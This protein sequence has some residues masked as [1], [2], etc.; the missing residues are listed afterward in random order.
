MKKFINENLVAIGIM[1]GLIILPLI[2][3]DSALIKGVGKKVFNN[4]EF[5][6]NYMTYIGTVILGIVTVIQNKRLHDENKELEDMNKN[7]LTLEKANY[8]PKMMIMNQN[9]NCIYTK[10]NEQLP[11]VINKIL[12]DYNKYYNQTPVY[13]YFV[14]V[15]ENPNKYIQLIMQYY[16][17][18]LSN[19]IKISNVIMKFEGEEYSRNAKLNDTIHMLFMDKTDCYFNIYFDS[20]SKNIEE[21]KF[22]VEIFMF[23]E[24]YTE[25]IIINFERN[26]IYKED[27]NTYI[28]NIKYFMEDND[29]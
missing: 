22:D 18:G 5:W 29:E 10:E 2:C 27:T 16:G 21:L 26:T 4:I 17:K 15:D 11:Q 14:S 3:I 25:Q 8:T 20:K 1:L 19:K 24:K 9:G 28:K 12:A 23:K 7:L 6:T 13:S